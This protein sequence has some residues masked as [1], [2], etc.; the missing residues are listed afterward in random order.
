MY[1]QLFHTEENYFCE[2]FLTDTLQG[3]HFL[4]SFQT[5]NGNIKLDHWQ[6]VV[7]ADQLRQVGLREAHKLTAEHLHPDN[8][9]KQNVRMAWEVNG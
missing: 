7:D 5:P 2:Y 3:L 9:Q 4:F 8:W 1:A 6:A